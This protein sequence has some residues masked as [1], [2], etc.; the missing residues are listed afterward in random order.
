MAGVVLI[1]YVLIAV[2]GLIFGSFFNVCIHR[3]PTRQSIAFPPSHCPKCQAPIKPWQNIPVISYILLGGRCANCKARI[4]WHYPL[5]EALTPILWLFLF[6]HFGAQFSLD[7]WKYTV[8]FTISLILFFI[9]LFH[10][11]LPDVLTLPLIVIGLGFALVP[12]ADVGILNA[13]SGGGFA[14]LFFFLMAWGYS[15]LRGKEGMGGGDVK[16][17]AA[18]G[19]FLGMPGILFAILFGSVLALVVA[20]LSLLLTKP[21]T[22]SDQLHQQAFPFG[23][24]LIIGALIQVLLA[25]SVMRLL[26]NLMP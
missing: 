16:Y 6:H 7:F 24:F 18:A 15:K 23:P 13:L 1:A 11:L 20:P 9:D 2:F 12:G 14:F 26:L 22:N 25:D 21:A 3:I 19:A 5:V 10:Q 8:F 17:I 4:H